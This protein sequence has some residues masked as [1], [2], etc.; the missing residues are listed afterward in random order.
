VQSI[1]VKDQSGQIIKPGQTPAPG[2]GP[3]DSDVNVGA[4][5]GGVVG[6]IILL[7]GIAAAVRYY[8]LAQ[9]NLKG[10]TGRESG[11]PNQIEPEVQPQPQ[12]QPQAQ[13][14]PQEVEEVS[15]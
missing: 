4:I 6:G 15:V 11:N 14:Q 2:P 1:V 3:K 7:V 8:F 5:I 10:E 9:K 12:A 13:A